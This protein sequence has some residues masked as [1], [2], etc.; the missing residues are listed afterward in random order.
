MQYSTIYCLINF[1][2]KINFEMSFSKDYKL[3]SCMKTFLYERNLYCK[4][5]YM[6]LR[7]YSIGFGFILDSKEM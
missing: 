2:K 5:L 6:G 1:D 4:A 7:C 3:I